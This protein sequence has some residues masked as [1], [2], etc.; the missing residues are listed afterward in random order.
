MTSEVDLPQ[1]DR[2]Q[3]AHALIEHLAV[4]SGIDLLH[5]KGYAAHESLYE[6]GRVSSDVD[7][8]VRPRDA[9][10]LAEVLVA[11]GWEAV[12]SFR[13]GSVFHHAMTLWN[14]QWGHVDIHRSFPGV[15][16]EP[17]A[18]FELLWAQ[19]DSTQIAGRPCRVPGRQH[20]ALLI[21]L[22][23]ARDPHRGASDVDFV[24]KARGREEWE[25]L[26]LLADQVGASITLAAATGRLGEWQGHPD[27]DIWHVA[28]R[29]GTRVEL[30]RARWRASR[31][32]RERWALLRGLLVVNR[33]H[34]RM[35]LLREPRPTDYAA[36]LRE[37][38]R[39][40]V[41]SLMA[42]RTTI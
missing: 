38:V 5:I 3:L 7:V 23:A 16:L 41:R 36:E 13:T 30:F 2:I 32:G 20:Q 40:A 8:L 33:D 24:R 26:E 31:S 6:K 18:F 34:L 14:E 22:H 9:A 1:A 21:V 11:D 10:Q 4:A 37:R 19:R 35:K 15:G 27:H 25:R 17:D 39:E 28:S 12:T 42:G 29:G